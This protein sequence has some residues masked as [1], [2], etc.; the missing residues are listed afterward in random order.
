MSI[1]KPYSKQK[2][3]LYHT[4]RTVS[5]ICKT[6]SHGMQP[7][8]KGLSRRDPGNEVD[9]SAVPSINEEGKAGY[10]CLDYVSVV[11]RDLSAVRLLEQEAPWL[12][13]SRRLG[14]D[15]L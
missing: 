6:R 11:D 14:K 13:M 3:Y 2:R 4:S 1:N 5:N 9:L 8:Y 15:S 10:E 12:R 7:R